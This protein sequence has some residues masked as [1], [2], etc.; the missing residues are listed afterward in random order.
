VSTLLSDS[1]ADSAAIGSVRPVVSFGR[2]TCGD[3][4]AA[5]RRE[6]LVT[7][8][9]GGY[10]AGTLA[11]IATRRY[12]GLLIAAL[13]PPVGRTVLVGGMVERAS[14]VDGRPTGRTFALDTQEYAGGTIDPQ[15]YRLAES[16]V[17]DGSVPVWTFA[18]DDALLERSIWME[19]GQNTTYVRYRLARSSRSVDLAVT[20]LV[21]YRDH[22]SLRS[23]MGWVPSV[24]LLPN[25]LIVRA[26]RSARP[27]HL[28]VAE[29]GRAELVQD[30]WWGFVH[31]EEAARGLDDR[32]D[33]FAAG[34][35]RRSLVPGETWTIV[36]SVP[37]EPTLDGDVALDRERARQHDLLVRAD[38]EGSS[39]FLRQ[40]VIAADQF[41][42][43]R[44]R[45]GETEPGTT[46]I[47][48]YH[49]F[50]D[51]G[52]DT[53]ISLP[54]L[55]LATGRA[56]EAA[57]ILRSFAGLVSDGLLPNNFPDRAGALPAYNTV[58]ASLWFVQAVRAYH[59][60]TADDGL[61]EDLLPTL[62]QIIDKHIAGTRFGIAVDPADGLLRAGEP[63][64]QLTWMD[65]KVNDS[66][67]TP[68]IG[69]PVE[70]NALWYNALRTVGAWV[71]RA[72]GEQAAHPYLGLAE[73]ALASFNEK[74]WRPS[75]GYCADVL[76]GAAGD[77][78]RMRPNQIFAVSLPYPLLEG[79]PAQRV[80]DA[81]GRSLL[82]SFGLRSL[83]PT[84]P[85]YR[86]MYGGNPRR[87]DEAYHQGP[88]WSWL[89]GAY[90]DA[91]E[92]VTG[93]RERALS[94]LRPFEAHLGDAGLGSIS[95][96]FDGDP[97]HMPRGAIAQA[98]GVAEVLRVW[99][100]LAG[101]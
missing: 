40:L 1:V 29:G 96:I 33:M 99:R 93:D 39:P 59:E 75:L 36:L 79:E 54:G 38:A 15:G 19:H 45:P 74:F 72:D 22:H 47:A 9:L 37:E 14:F 17:L 23:G 82:T 95:E 85:A 55:T 43:G 84:D 66:V 52:R 24:E 63:G 12:H 87:R 8:G 97:P 27:F 86:G 73:Q 94:F 25:G 20:P 83:A 92:R 46:V 3:L 21:T 30:W 32:S 88:V 62:R 57:A 101:E 80:V 91:V 100:R 69:K 18:L 67:V 78:L 2:E 81:V 26:G 61:V 4:P 10:A 98:W 90:A 89:I 16:F 65:A 56:V 60:A 28:L 64:L 35:L 70:I 7:N 71:A 6:W 77:E 48:G 31:R 49:W 76:D 68:R 5:L 41:V 42:V 13:E 51:W 58:D 53:M 44:D 34:T 50:N 11:G